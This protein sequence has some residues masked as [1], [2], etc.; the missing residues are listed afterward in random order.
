MRPV[1]NFG[2]YSAYSTVDC[3]RA[4]RLL[5]NRFKIPT[6]FFYNLKYGFFIDPNTEIITITGKGIKN[7]AHPD[8]Y[9]PTKADI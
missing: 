1:I 3:F 7:D 6:A 4:I 5:L 2:E 9:E 8:G